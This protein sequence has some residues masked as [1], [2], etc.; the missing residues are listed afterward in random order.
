MEGTPR[1]LHIKT[2]MERQH[3]SGPRSWRIRYGSTTQLNCD[4]CEQTAGYNNKR[5]GKVK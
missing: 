3:G 1:K 2:E 4:E 5:T